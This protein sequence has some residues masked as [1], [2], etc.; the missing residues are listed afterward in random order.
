MSKNK[1]QQKPRDKVG[2]Y[3]VDRIREV[4]QERDDYRA[5]FE[6]SASE[7]SLLENKVEKFIEVQKLFSLEDSGNVKAII[8]HDLNGGYQTMVAIE[9]SEDFNKW[10][11][12]LEL[13]EN[14]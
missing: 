14:E 5:R 12:L 6:L 2:E 8:M 7:I 4:E 9:T 13:K 11:E 3:L 10:I 1:T